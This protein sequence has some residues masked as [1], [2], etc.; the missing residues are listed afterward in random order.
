MKEEPIEKQDV[1]NIAL[2]FCKH[3][4][5]DF[6]NKN[7]CSKHEE[8]CVHQKGNE[9]RHCQYCDMN[10]VSLE[11][12]LE[13]KV[14]CVNYLL[15]QAESSDYLRCA[16]CN[17][18]FTTTN[19]VLD[20]MKICPLKDE[21]KK[22]SHEYYKIDMFKTTQ[23]FSYENCNMNFLSE[24]K[25]S[26]HK[27][28]CKK[29]ISNKSNEMKFMC[30]KCC[31]NFP[32]SKI[33]LEHNATYNGVNQGL[34][35]EKTE[36][37][38]NMYEDL[39][40]KDQKEQKDQKDQ[41]EQ[42]EQKDQKNGYGCDYCNLT[43]TDELFKVN[44]EILCSFFAD[45]NNNN[46]NISLEKGKDNKFQPIYLCQHCNFQFNYEDIKIEHEIICSKR[47]I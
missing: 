23:P 32:T 13:H 21:L 2:F 43:F 17:L 8:N 41:K 42:Q 45:N 33:A 6:M 9:E 28:L 40:L 12:D 47:K 24:E 3:C 26:E 31:N 29:Y 11:A 19:Q 30:A 22:P 25:K 39:S 36:T 1:C 38:D 5:I 7:E 4:C 34:L 18:N 44:H 16:E 20:H 46:N 15:E 27:G 37:C 35:E 14:S 10:F